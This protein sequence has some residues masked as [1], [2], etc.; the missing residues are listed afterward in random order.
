[1]LILFL[2]SF[3]LF[4]TPGNSSTNQQT[5]IGQQG[6]H[7]GNHHPRLNLDPNGGEPPAEDCCGPNPPPTPPPSSR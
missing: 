5:T 7:S 3:L 2:L 4:G 6:K 1:M